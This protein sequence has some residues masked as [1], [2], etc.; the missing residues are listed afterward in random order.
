MQPPYP[1]AEFLSLDVEAALQAVLAAQLVGVNVGSIGEKD[2]NADGQLVFVPP[3]VRTRH[4]GTDYKSVESQQLTYNAEHIMEIWC[5]DKDLRSK[6]A[7]RA[8]TEALLATVLA[9]VAG[10]RLVLSDGV[11]ESEPIRLMGVTDIYAEGRGSI[12]VLAV[13]VPGVAQFPGTNA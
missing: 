2:L 3:V 9:L 11:T 7:Q 8:A 5:C 1:G 13:A 12:Y 4:G 10:A 6:E